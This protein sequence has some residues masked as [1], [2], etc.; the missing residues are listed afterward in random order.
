MRISAKTLAAALATSVSA[1]V[2]AAPLALMSSSASG[3]D[4]APAVTAIDPAPRGA[5]SQAAVRDLVAEA[6]ASLGEGMDPAAYDIAGLL[7]IADGIDTAEIDRRANA[8]ALALADDYANGLIQQRTRYDWHIEAPAMDR[9]QLANG[10]REAV[11]AG[12][13]RPW[14]RSLLPQDPRYAALRHAYATSGDAA[15]RDRLRVNLERWRWMPRTL[16]EDHIYVNVPSY[17]LAVVNDG[18]AVSQYTVVVGSPRTPTPQL[19]LQASSIVVNPSWTVPESIARRGLGGGFQRIS[20]GG[21]TRYVQAPGP[22]NALGKFK[23]DMPNPHA[24]YLHDTPS[25]GLFARD[26]RAFSHGCIRVKDIDR[27]AAELVATDD[28]AEASLERAAAGSATR[29][30]ALDR[31]LPVYLV[32]FTADVGA[33]GQVKMLEDPYGRD[34]RVLADLNPARRMVDKAPT[35]PTKA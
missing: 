5:W 9:M 12:G 2:A 25:K 26:S 35:A 8:L 23:I 1:L 14:L 11:A 21:F 4:P 20:T 29:T 24:I 3:S 28:G 17:T 27:L 7:A 16:G 15:V 22:R 6:H 34:A 30:V 18:Q 31:K 10:L 32:Y 19:A 13:V 33:D